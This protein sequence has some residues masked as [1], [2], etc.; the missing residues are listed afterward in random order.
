MQSMLRS[1]LVINDSSCLK[2]NAREEKKVPQS[3]WEQH[4]QQHRQLLQCNQFHSV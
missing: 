4:K 1:K 2:W 3:S